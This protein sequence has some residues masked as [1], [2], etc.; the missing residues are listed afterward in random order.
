MD[1]DQPRRPMQAA[2]SSVVDKVKSRHRFSIVHC[3]TSSPN[4][5]D[6]HTNH[7][8]NAGN[9]S[10]H[11][12]YLFVVSI[13]DAGFNMLSSRAREA[14]QENRVPTHMPRTPQENHHVSHQ[15]YRGLSLP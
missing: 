2:E 10:R 14:P 13:H 7:Q 12:S 1:T 3:H 15:T 6:R 9:Y 5:Q 4:S 11:S 8:S